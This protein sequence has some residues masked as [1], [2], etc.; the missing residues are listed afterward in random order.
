MKP[1]ICYIV[2]ALTN[3]YPLGI[4]NEFIG[5]ESHILVK[6]GTLLVF[7]PGASYEKAVY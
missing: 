4:S 5:E 3:N 7:F 2:G 1:N 6:R